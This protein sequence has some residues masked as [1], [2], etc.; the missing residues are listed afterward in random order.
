MFD[1]ANMASVN[2]SRSQYF[3]FFQRNK[4][5]AVCLNSAKLLGVTKPNDDNNDVKHTVTWHKMH[6]TFD[7]NHY[8]DVTMGWWRLKSPAPRLFSQ[9][10]IRAQIKEDI[11]APRH[12]PLCGEFTDDRWIPRTNGQWRGNVSNW[13]RHHALR[14]NSFDE[15]MFWALPVEL[16]SCDWG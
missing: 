4:C 7:P 2:R 3:F 11:K 14:P 15:L 16:F 1:S 5:M 13:W 12:W 6:T 10:F 8:C 9:P